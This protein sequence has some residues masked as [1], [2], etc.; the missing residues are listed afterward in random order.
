M[1]I[2]LLD[3]ERAVILEIISMRSTPQ[4]GVNLTAA[5]VAAKVLDDFAIPDLNVQTA[6]EAKRHDDFETDLETL[7]WVYDELTSRLKQNKMPASRAI[8]IVSLNDKLRIITEDENLQ[9]DEED[10]KRGKNNA[11]IDGDKG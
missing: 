10:K 2:N 7:N 6:A 11:T 9:R 1:I 8:Y 5:R 4:E 3:G